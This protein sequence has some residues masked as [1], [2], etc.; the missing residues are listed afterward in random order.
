MRRAKESES[1]EEARISETLSFFEAIF[2]FFFFFEA[3]RKRR[4]RKFL[5]AFS[6]SQSPEERREH[7]A[8]FFFFFALFLFLSLS[9]RPKMENHLLRHGEAMEAELKAMGAVQLGVRK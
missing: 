3:G 1:S 8:S 4:R 7:L 5:F 9:P 6:H 2:F